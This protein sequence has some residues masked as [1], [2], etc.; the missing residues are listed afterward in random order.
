M[1]LDTTVIAGGIREASRFL[2]LDLLIL[3]RVTLS[4]EQY[5]PQRKLPGVLGV[6]IEPCSAPVHLVHR[7]IISRVQARELVEPGQVLLRGP[8]S[9]VDWTLA[10]PP[11]LSRPCIGS[12]VMMPLERR[13]VVLGNQGA[14]AGFN[15]EACKASAGHGPDGSS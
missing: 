7:R 5:W 2:G 15:L 8:S 9:R 1:V 12:Q 4:I 6:A 13:F 14:Q 10:I 3:A 11:L